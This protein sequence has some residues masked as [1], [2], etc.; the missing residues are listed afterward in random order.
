MADGPAAEA[1]HAELGTYYLYA[2]GDHDAVMLFCDNETDS[3]RAG[4]DSSRGGYWKDA[5][6]ERVVAGRGDAVNPTQQGTKAALWYAFEVPAGGQRQIQLRLSS[7]ALVRPFGDF[8]AIFRDRLREADEFYAS[9]Q[10]GIESADARA[11]QRQAFAGMIWSKQF[12]YFDVPEWLYGDPAQPSPPPTRR[13]G[14]NCEWM[15]L[16]NADILSMPDKWEYPW[17]AA[18]DLA[19]HCVAL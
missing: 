13:G 19:F 18:W 14:R 7:R 5:F 3:G 9:L 15:H 4:N 6:H 8:A 1:C 10:Q 11:V 2:D 17:W 16:N 12:Y